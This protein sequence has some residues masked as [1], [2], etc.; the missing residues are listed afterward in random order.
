LVGDDF[1]GAQRKEAFWRAGAKRPIDGA[2]QE[3]EVPVTLDELFRGAEKS[4]TLK[5]S[6]ASGG[7]GEERSFRV[8]IPKG[9]TDGS[10]IRLKGQA[11]KG[12]HGG[13]DGDL[14]LTLKLVLQPGFGVSG[15]DVHM[16]LPV[17]PWEAVLGSKVSVKT[18]AG[19]FVVK[20][21]EGSQTGTVL[22]LSGKGLPK[23]NGM[24]GDLQLT[25]Q[26][27]VPKSPS[28]D[29]RKLFK[30]LE[31]VSRFQPRA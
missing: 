31:K 2:D 27:V 12:Q 23:R 29:E 19:D 28:D 30:E 24:T 20:V 3:A 9:S 10:R 15:Y 4:V 16:T 17:A 8:K 6:A 7:P 1:K 5:Q 13:R 14:F 25:L 11:R 21:P 26:V 18:P 22:R